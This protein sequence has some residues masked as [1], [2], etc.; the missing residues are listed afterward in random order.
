LGLFLL[1]RPKF[2]GKHYSLLEGL[3]ALCYTSRN[4]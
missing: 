4:G 3:M 2:I 1:Q